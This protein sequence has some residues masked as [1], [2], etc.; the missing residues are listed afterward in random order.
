MRIINIPLSERRH[1]GGGGGPYD[2]VYTT[3]ATAI[4]HPA[5]THTCVV[6]AT[7]YTAADGPDT[8]RRPDGP[9][10]PVQSKVGASCARAI[11]LAVRGGG[12]VPD[13]VATRRIR[14]HAARTIYCCLYKYIT[15]SLPKIEDLVYRKVRQM[16]RRV[17]CGR[18]VGGRLCR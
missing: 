11:A 18:F 4:R 8:P 1:G 5:H 17:V 6:H 13:D 14:V 3:L 9:A 16:L 15:Y 2:A 12:G 10:P 7:Y